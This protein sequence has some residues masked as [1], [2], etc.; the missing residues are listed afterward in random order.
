MKLEK[1][2]LS[3]ITQ[4]QKN[5]FCICILLHVSVSYY[6]FDKQTTILKSAFNLTK[7]ISPSNNSVYECTNKSKYQ[8]KRSL[9]FYLY[10]TRRQYSHFRYCSHIIEGNQDNLS[11]SSQS[12][13]EPKTFLI[14]TFL[15]V[16]RGRFKLKASY[17]MLSKTF[18]E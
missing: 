15:I 2:I 16:S 8:V 14:E 17:H 18:V 9:S 7:G 11:R 13:T 4:I 5:K 12:S 10:L 1:I 6:I 3:E